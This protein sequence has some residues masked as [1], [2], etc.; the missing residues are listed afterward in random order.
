MCIIPRPKVI[1]VGKLLDKAVIINNTAYT[2]ITN[3]FLSNQL[4]YLGC[5]SKLVKA[6]HGPFVFIGKHF[7]EELVILPEILKAEKEGYYIKIDH[8]GIFLQASAEQGLFYAIQT[9]IQINEQGNWDQ[10]LEIMDWPDNKIRGFHFELRYGI[11]KF[12]RVLSI[13]DELALYKFNTLIIE[14]EDKFPYDKN[15][16]IA[17]SLAFTSEEIQKI[18]SYA[19]ERYLE[20]IPLQQT[21][22]HLE[23]VLKNDKYYSLKEVKEPIE[24]HEEPFTFR[25]TGFHYYNSIDEICPSNE[26]SYELVEGLCDEIIE[27]HH[28]SKYVH[29]GCDEA[30]NLLTCKDCIKKYGQEGSKKLFIEHINRM[31]SRIIAK[32]KIPIIWDD[33][34]RKFKDEDF[35][36]LGKDI[37]LMCWLYFDR[38]YQLARK[39]ISKYKRFGFKV[40]GASSA[41]C[42]EEP[43]PSYFDMPH[44]EERKKCIEI[45][46]KLSNEFD[47]EGI[48]TTAWSNYTG[49]IA[50][51]HP[52]FDTIWYTVIFSAEKYWNTSGSSDSFEEDFMHNFFGISDITGSF[53]NDNKR[54]N[55][56]FTYIQKHCTRHAYIAEVYKL[57]ALLSTY[58][59]KSMYT[60]NELYKL[61]SAVTL[62]EKD[63]VLKK[64][65][66]L[67]RMRDKLIKEVEQLLAS[68]YYEEDIAEFI[69]SRF[70]VDDF[71]YL[72]ISRRGLL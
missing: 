63:I 41:K 19:S 45:W 24:E 3:K 50:P 35:K 29:I 39:L 9:L 59:V 40:I 1:N 8:A 54:T 38:D 55:D 11:P 22:G 12:E 34:L 37:V 43:N 67:K 21:L 72:N 27:K 42:C 28:K 51:P 70:L 65:D 71:L 6:G 68:Y 20:I 5:G 46:A 33:M 23:Y 58:R 18:Q 69:R 14:Y 30:W 2:N 64:I 13:I 26:K 15:S 36:L 25:Y 32:G 52:F 48:I 57:M 44:M 56:N 66:E 62:H 17:S 4:E 60:N 16:D 49:T 10:E 61:S 53:C 31:G 7:D 47:I